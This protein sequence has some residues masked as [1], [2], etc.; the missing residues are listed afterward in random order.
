L[1]MEDLALV[2]VGGLSVMPENY[3]FNL[4]AE[5]DVES[6][7]CF[8]VQATPKRADKYLFNKKGRRCL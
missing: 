4:L 1:L 5:E 7:H 3:T 8:F 2:V 6:Y